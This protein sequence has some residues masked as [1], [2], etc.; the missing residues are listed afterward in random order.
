VRALAAEFAKTLSTRMWWLLLVIL[1][2]YVGLAAA[3]LG[4]ALTLAPDEAGMDVGGASLA[5]II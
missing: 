3:G 1:V 5:T 2:G 4:L